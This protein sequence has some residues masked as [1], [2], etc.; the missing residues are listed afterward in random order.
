M[1]P[2]DGAIGLPGN[3]DDGRR[4]V[5]LDQVRALAGLLHRLIRERDPLVV[6]PQ[7]R[8]PFGVLDAAPPLVEQVL[9]RHVRSRITL[10]RRIGVTTPE[11]S[12]SVSRCS[13][14]TVKVNACVSVALTKSAMVLAVSSSVIRLLP[15]DSVSSTSPVNGSVH[16]ICAL[17]PAK[18]GSA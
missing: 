8:R 17:H 4:R 15:V 9:Q 10:P 5:V 6:A 3:R 11:P 1:Q 18:L 2:V 7:K 13:A 14:S 16:T 12:V